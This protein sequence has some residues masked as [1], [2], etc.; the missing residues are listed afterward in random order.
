MYKVSTHEFIWTEQ[1]Y[2][3]PISCAMV[4]AVDSPVSSFMVQLRI[5]LHIPSIGAKPR[6]IKSKVNQKEPWTKVE[7]L[8]HIVYMV[9]FNQ[10]KGF[11][12]LDIYQAC[13]LCTGYYMGL[14]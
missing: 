13:I 8:Q 7:C 12:T 2:L 4:K 11:T 9:L 3:C 10:K 1:S 5:R 14:V 6:E